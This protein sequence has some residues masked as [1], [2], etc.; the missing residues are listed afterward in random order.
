MGVI[1]GYTLTSNLVNIS[2]IA[3]LARME[4]A[5]LTALIIQEYCSVTNSFI[6]MFCG[7]FAFQSAVYYVKNNKQ[8][9]RR[10]RWAIVRFIIN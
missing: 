2:Q 5:E 1:W 7:A 8:Y 6:L 3:P 9:I 4:T 10:L